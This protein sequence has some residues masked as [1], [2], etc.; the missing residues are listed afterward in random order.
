MFTQR[1]RLENSYNFLNQQ[2]PVGAQHRQSQSNPPIIDM[3]Q[4]QDIIDIMD[5]TGNGVDI[6]HNDGGSTMEGVFTNG[7]LSIVSA[8]TEQTEGLTING[9][10]TPKQARSSCSPGGSII[11]PPTYTSFC[12]GI[13]EANKS[14]LVGINKWMM[15]AAH[16][17]PSISTSNVNQISEI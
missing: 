13:D 6:D 11:N 12:V 2:L 16:N 4:V 10:N 5:L 9:G 14:I 15:Q 7:D 3:S 1:R 17:T 8:V